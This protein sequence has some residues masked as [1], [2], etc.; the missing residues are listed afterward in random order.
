MDQGG[1]SWFDLRLIP[2]ALATWAGALGSILVPQVA[3]WIA[4]GAWG[5]AGVM[6]A[7]AFLRPRASRGELPHSRRHTPSALRAWGNSPRFAQEGSPTPRRASDGEFP[8]GRTQ[9]AR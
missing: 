6:L 5:S 9:S 1:S 7:L 4:V 8:D 2:V 3:V